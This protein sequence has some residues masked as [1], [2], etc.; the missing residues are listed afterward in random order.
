MDGAAAL[1]APV[2]LD[3]QLGATMAWLFLAF[4][5]VFEIA[6]TTALKMSEGFTRLGPSLLI[7][8]AYTL[9]F[10]LLGMAVREIPIS[11]AY[12]IWSA[13]G[14]AAIT[15]IGMMLFREPLTLIKVAFIGLIII[16]V[17]GLHVTSARESPLDS[18]TTV[19][20]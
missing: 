9:S 14:T 13:I 5:I 1:P 11:I 10:V 8:P 15:V 3:K 19:E 12:A 6:G 18:K 7:L 2:L 16:G 17:V 20:E 4:A